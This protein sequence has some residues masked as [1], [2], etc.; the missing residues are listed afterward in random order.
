M[1][2]LVCLCWSICCGL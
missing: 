1:I 2:L